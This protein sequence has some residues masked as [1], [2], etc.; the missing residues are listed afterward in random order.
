MLQVLLRLGLLFYRK[1]LLK[2][3]PR[4]WGVGRAADHGQ[5]PFTDIDH[6]ASVSTHGWLRR[7]HA[8]ALTEQFSHKFFHS[9]PL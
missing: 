7:G 1:Q 2:T 3:H 5:F 9:P 6:A 8:K 4:C